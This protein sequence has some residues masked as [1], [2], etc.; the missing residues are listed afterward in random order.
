M[1]LPQICRT[2]EIRGY[3]I[4]GIIHNSS[5]FFTDLEVF[6]DGL[7]WCWEMVDLARFEAKLRSGWV[8]TSVPDD[9]PLDIHGIGSFSFSAAN[10][11]HTQKS[12][13]NL[14]KATVKEL[15]PRLENL[16]DCHGRDVEVINGVRYKAVGH[17]NPR[18]WK[19][20]KPITPLSR[21]V[22]GRDVR[23]FCSVGN[24]LYL[25][26]IQIFPDD[27]VVIS[28][29]PEELVLPFGELRNQL[30]DPKKFRLPEPGEKV[31]IDQLATLV[32]REWDWKVDEHQ[33]LAE[34]YDVREQALGKPG[35]IR[36][37]MQAYEAYLKNQ[38]KETLSALRNAYEAVPEHLRM[39][40]GDM[41]TKDIPIRMILYGKDEIKNWSHYAVSKAEGMELPTI[42]IPE[43]PSED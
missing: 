21:G 28:G 19:T 27:T 7:I 9:R 25:T 4:P 2:K 13:Y 10:W 5:Y 40:C 37:C 32:V 31:V 14:V 42:E 22:F 30:A 17:D 41:D 33:L 11:A 35:A 8:V 6:A 16:Y 39:Y 36:T 29:I 43:S 34:I 12:L 1:N 20:Q 3:S 24:T 15:N 23:H 26:T 38:T 18:P